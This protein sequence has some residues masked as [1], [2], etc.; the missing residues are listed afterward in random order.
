MGRGAA[1][2]GGRLARGGVGRAASRA[3][4]PGGGPDGDFSGEKMLHGSAAR[5]PSLWSGEEP[6]RVT[7]AG[8]SDC[9]PSPRAPGGGR[10]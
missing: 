9:A 4:A 8:G 5:G 6:A 1:G 10:M 7:R 3:A 2:G